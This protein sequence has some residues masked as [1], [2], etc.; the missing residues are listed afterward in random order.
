MPIGGGPELRLID[1]VG[2]G[3]GTRI[4][5]VPGGIFYWSRAGTDGVWPLLFFD[6]SSRRSIE[7]TRSRA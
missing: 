6:L 3:N 5:V 2:S 4:A 1:F 7:L